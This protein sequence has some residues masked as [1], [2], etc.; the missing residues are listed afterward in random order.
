MQRQHLG[1]T[2][3]PWILGTSVACN[4]QGAPVAAT[5]LAH[6]AH[7]VHPTSSLTTS[8]PLAKATSAARSDA[9]DDAADLIR[10]S[11]SFTKA[12]ANE[13]IVVRHGGPTTGA[14]GGRTAYLFSGASTEPVRTITD[15]PASQCSALPRAGRHSLLMCIMQNTW[16][17]A[18]SYHVDLYDLSRPFEPVDATEQKERRA[19][20]GWLQPLQVLLAS[21]EDISEQYTCSKATEAHGPSSVFPILALVPTPRDL[22]SEPTGAA[23]FVLRVPVP[24]RTHVLKVCD[25]LQKRMLS[26][27]VEFGGMD[28][29]HPYTELAVADAAK[30]VAGEPKDVV[31]AYTLDP[32]G[33]HLTLVRAPEVILAIAPLGFRIP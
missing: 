33:D 14:G 29:P 23:R 20:T 25:L 2:L 15:F 31:F 28:G 27:E 1:R 17:G 16:S 24:A 10:V 32:S 13:R 30:R 3:C 19:N 4:P 6:P 22:Q 5:P 8:V 11:G 26:D 9:E 12:S 21:K 7:H 18:P